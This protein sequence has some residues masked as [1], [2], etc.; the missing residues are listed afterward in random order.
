[1]VRLLVSCVTL[2]LVVACSIS[3]HEF[4]KNSGQGGGAGSAA[5]SDGVAG[6]S[7]ATSMAGTAVGGSAADGGTNSD[8]GTNG[9]TAGSSSSST[10]GA[11]SG[12]SAGDTGLSCN[13]DMKECGGKCVDVTDPAY[14]CGKTSCDA[15]ACPNPGQG[16]SLVCSGA[17]C[18]IGSCGTDFKLCDDKCVALSDPTYGCGKTSCDASACPSAGSGTLVCQGS[19]CVL[20]TC[21]TDTKK[22][23]N[24][25]VPTDR[26]NGCAAAGECAACANN[27]ECL[28]APSAC[29]CVPVA[30]A[31]ACAGKC[32][33]V[34]NGCGG[35]HDCGGCTLPQT[36]NGGGTPNVCGCMS[37]SM[38]TACLNKA[39]GTV[40]NGCSGTYT[41]GTCTAQPNAVA[42]C[43][44]NS[45]VNACAAGIMPLTCP[46]IA[47]GM[48]RCGAWSFETN[49]AEGWIKGDPS[50]AAITGKTSIATGTAQKV[51]GSRSL[52][53]TTTIPGGENPSTYD[54]E[55]QITFEAPLCPDASSLNL[56][57]RVF[58][59]H[60][61]FERISGTPLTSANAKLTAGSQQQNPDGTG[62]S[63]GSA[64]FTVAEGTWLSG[65]A[66]VSVA[67]THLTIT[68]AVIPRLATPW[69]GRIYFDL[70]ALH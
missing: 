48:P 28:G 53:V 52:V 9:Q 30:K 59:V 51:D 50:D 35:T 41:C 34:S 22:C 66:Q 2:G 68:V 45:C 12:G 3:E 60:A 29:T 23:G 14:G 5:K 56:S 13:A 39:C 44:S 20:G 15:S 24:K 25:C 38:A 32:G 67:A 10:A 6:S 19:S 26:S 37:T 55:Q 64:P 63:V 65:T 69:N 16:G 27:E 8:G 70:L 43:E 46:N 58:E 49:T 42:T 54:Y 47:P 33:S 40:S 4:S 1:M 21:G 18:K 57:N 17:S 7:V 61:Y 36:C 11:T 62:G 31:T